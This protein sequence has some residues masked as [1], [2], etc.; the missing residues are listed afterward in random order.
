MIAAATT[1]TSVERKAEISMHANKKRGLYDLDPA[2]EV[3]LLLRLLSELDI[4]RIFK[5]MTSVRK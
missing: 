2:L 3:A 5:K 1:T 4:V